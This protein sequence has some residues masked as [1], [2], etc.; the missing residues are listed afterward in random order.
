VHV[1]KTYNIRL[2][3]VLVGTFKSFAKERM[4]EMNIKDRL[5][6]VWENGKPKQFAKIFKE[7]AISRGLE[8][9]NNETKD[10]SNKYLALSTCGGITWN[11]VNCYYML[12]KERFGNENLAITLRKKSGSYFIIERNGERAFE[13]DYSGIR[14]YKEE[15]LN[16]IIEEHKPF[17]EILFAGLKKKRTVK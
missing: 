15:L 3:E 5:T 7:Y 9:V 6:Q 8:Q 14:H 13:V 16:E 10:Y 4:I 2:N 12:E 17:F 11:R 1:N